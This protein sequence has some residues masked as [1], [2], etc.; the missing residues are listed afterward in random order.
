MD[1]IHGSLEN[2]E[3]AQIAME[4]IEN[5]LTK[6]GCNIEEYIWSEAKPTVTIKQVANKDQRTVQLMMNSS[7]QLQSEKVFGL[8]WN[9]KSD[10]LTYTF[11]ADKWK[12]KSNKVTKRKILTATS[13][14]Y[15]L[16]GLVTP[17][18]VKTKTILK[19][20]GNVSKNWMG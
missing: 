10:H 4:N 14:I 15:D 13:S 5:I 20:L 12:Y 11:G 16:L 9:V 2:V 6:R 19:N 18:T 17:I 3:V 7:E 1:D 8:Q